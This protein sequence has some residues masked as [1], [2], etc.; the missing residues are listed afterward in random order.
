MHLNSN[1]LIWIEGESYGWQTPSEIQHL[2]A[3]MNQ[4]PEHKNS[5]D[6]RRHAAEGNASV[7]SRHVFVSLPAPYHPSP[8]MPEEVSIEERADLLRKKVQT[9]AAEERTNS[10]AENISTHTGKIDYTGWAFKKKEKSSVNS[11]IIV[12]CSLGLILIAVIGW[13]AS[14]QDSSEKKS[15]EVVLRQT[16]HASEPVDLHE[17][18]VIVNAEETSADQ[19]TGRDEPAVVTNASTAQMRLQK[20]TM[21]VGEVQRPLSVSE[22]KEIT[23]DVSAEEN[24]PQEAEQKREKKRR[25]L[26]EVIHSLFAKQDV[27]EAEQQT[28]SVITNGERITRKR[29]EGNGQEAPVS[30]VDAID[31]RL[32]STGDDWMMGVQNLKVKLYNNSDVKLSTATIQLLYYSEDNVQLDKKT[33]QFSNVPS[34]KSQTIAAPDHR[35]ADHVTYEIISATGEGK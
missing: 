9:L 29:D 19:P 7:Q 1:D 16:S 22:N 6:G 3:Y 35:T 8:S 14:T 24:V 17:A 33:I 28:T 13:L 4:S 32:Q 30:L 2:K 10:S 26:K 21:M 11:K 31:I 20:N 12:A 5:F 15:S 23:N 25:T 27:T 18:P 34:R